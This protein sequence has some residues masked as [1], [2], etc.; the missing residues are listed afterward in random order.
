MTRSSF[1]PPIRWNSAT[2]LPPLHDRGERCPQGMLIG[3]AQTDSDRVAVV[4]EK[5]AR[6][7]EITIHQVSGSVHTVLADGVAV[8]VIGR[9]TGPAVSI[10][11]VLLVEQCL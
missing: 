2:G 4:Y 7:P 6:P 1:S 3:D 5:G 11:E 10:D 8:A 9:A